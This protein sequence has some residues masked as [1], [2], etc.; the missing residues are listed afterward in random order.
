[1][2]CVGEEKVKGRGKGRQGAACIHKNAKNCVHPV[3]QHTMPPGLLLL[4]GIIVCGI[5]GSEGI[6]LLNFRGWDL[7][8]FIF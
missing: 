1:M 8:F 6:F 7:P 4:F 2:L 3:F 5:A